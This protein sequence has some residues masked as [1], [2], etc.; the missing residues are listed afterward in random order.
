MHTTDIVVAGLGAVIVAALVSRAFYGA[1][2]V[3]MLMEEVAPVSADGSGPA[4]PSAPRWCFHGREA[5]LLDLRP[6]RQ[7]CP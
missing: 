3:A 1:G 2:P 7:P 4:R 5:D 6:A